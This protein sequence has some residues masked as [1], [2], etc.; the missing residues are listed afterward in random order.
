VSAP[1]LD[2]ASLFAVG[3]VRQ[4]G[5]TATLPDQPGIHLL[6]DTMLSPRDA[7]ALA[8]PALASRIGMTAA[9]RLAAAPGQR[10]PE[11]VQARFVNRSVFEMFAR[12]FRYGGP[13]A[14]G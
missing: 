6:V 8:L 3:V 4:P 10:D 7:A 11:D 2:S 5:V 1:P 13:F 9:A 12:A 14:D